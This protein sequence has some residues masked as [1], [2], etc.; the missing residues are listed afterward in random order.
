MP[1]R[2]GQLL[3]VDKNEHLRDV[4]SS[5]AAWMRSAGIVSA[6]GVSV[7]AAGTFLETFPHVD[8][9]WVLGLLLF[10]TAVPFVVECF[11]EFSQSYVA[12]WALI[13][14]ALLNLAGSPLGVYEYH[15][16]DQMALIILVWLMGE[17][18]SI[19]RRRDVIGVTVAAL[20]ISVGR[21][22][23]DETYTSWM[24]WLA[25]IGIAFLAGLFIRT[26]VVALV[27]MR[28]AQAALREQATTEERQRIAREVHDVIAHSLTVTMLHL[29]A[30]RMAVAR[31]DNVAA[32]EALE[33]AERAGRTSL[34][35][36]RHTVGLLRT[37]GASTQS[38]APLPTASDVPELVDSYRAAG[39]DVT[40][41]LDG[42][43]DRVD[44]AAGLAL[45]RIVQ[46]SL[47]NAGR[48]APGAHTVVRI[49]V[50][51]PLYVDVA[52]E[53]GAATSEHGSGL[54]LEGMAER[55]A[56]LGG[57]LHAGRY[58][59]GWRVAATIP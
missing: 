43:L 37:N 22:A 47:T 51:P 24:V 17:T 59:D 45:Y 50:G 56:A 3:T 8:R 40:L 49:A 16:R 31:G 58:G 28:V 20:V 35:E 41:D 6:V 13:P 4:L 14:L 33:E 48:H 1:S 32:T 2:V 25:G 30:A 11:T 42:D 39:V 12:A 9:P 57:S 26:L 21:L 34:N 52:S 44:P 10:A 53:G 15:G 5:D 29:T 46:E 7:V 19:G 54:G 55:A 36:I 27:N 23:V 18:A 38:R